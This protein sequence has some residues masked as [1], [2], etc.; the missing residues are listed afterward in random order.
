[1]ELVIPAP[2]LSSVSVSGNSAAF[3]VRRI[4][5]VGRNYADHAREMGMDPHREPPFFFGKPKDTLGPGGE[6]TPLPHAPP[7]VAFHSTRR[8][9]HPPPPLARTPPRPPPP[10]P[11]HTH[12]HNIF[13]VKGAT[14]FLT[15]FF[16]FL[17]FS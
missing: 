4:Y 3:P 13:F 16:F 17:C 14:A 12:T 6:H 7:T 10:P 8:D 15:H 5:C 1:M 11:P 2:A 9:V